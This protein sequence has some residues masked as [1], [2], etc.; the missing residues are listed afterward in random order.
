MIISVPKEIVSGERRVALTPDV[1][2]RLVGAGV[3]VR[4]ETG[5]GIEASYPDEAYTKVGAEI[6]NDGAAAWKDSDVVVKIQPP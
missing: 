5:A 3:T 6:V 2:K 4:V 1:A